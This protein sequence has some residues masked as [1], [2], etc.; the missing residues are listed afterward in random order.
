MSP[1]PAV[2]PGHGPIAR[3]PGVRRNR[4][5]VGLRG[6]YGY[7]PSGTDVTDEDR[8]FGAAT[9]ESAALSPPPSR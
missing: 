4:A 3:I 7:P 8:A 2:V 1:I 9:P 6:R 5:G